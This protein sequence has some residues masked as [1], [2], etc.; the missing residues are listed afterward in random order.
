LTTYNDWL[1]EEREVAVIEIVT[2]RTQIAVLRDNCK[3]SDFNRCNVVTVNIIGEATMRRHLKTPRRPDFASWIRMCGY[4]DVCTENA[5]YEDP[6]L[7][8]HI[9][10]G[11]IK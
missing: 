2:G 3:F 8:S 1:G 10:S 11:A 6:E 4:M 9:W 5:Q 7:M